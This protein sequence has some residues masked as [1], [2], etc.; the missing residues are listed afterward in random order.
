MRLPK[1]YDYEHQTVTGFITC[2]NIGITHLENHLVKNN[3][4]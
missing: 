1:N 4:F 2:E 3:N